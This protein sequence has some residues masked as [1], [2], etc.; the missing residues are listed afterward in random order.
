[1]KIKFIGGNFF[2][3]KKHE[4]KIQRLKHKKL[5]YINISNKQPYIFY[6]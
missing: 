1:M 3:K 6:S 4:F 5:G 2:F